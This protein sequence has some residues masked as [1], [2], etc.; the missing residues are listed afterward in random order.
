MSRNAH[1][2]PVMAGILEAFAANRPVAAQQI[3]TGPLEVDYPAAV[4]E[5]GRSHTD[6]IDEADLAPITDE[7][8]F[9]PRGH[10]SE[11]ERLMDELGLCEKDFR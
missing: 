9:E 7:T 3:G 5:E 4:A 2:H 10:G 11:R 8:L 1:V 6:V